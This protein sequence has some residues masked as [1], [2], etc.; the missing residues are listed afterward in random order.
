MLVFTNGR[1]SVKN[2]VGSYSFFVGFHGKGLK[3]EDL[4]GLSQ[5]GGQTQEEKYPAKRFWKYK[6]TIH[7][8][9]IIILGIEVG[10][11]KCRAHMIKDMSG[12]PA[13]HR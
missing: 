8:L 2:A 10:T 13:W 7:L 9:S 11:E 1:K 12:Y 3:G 6:L 4:A 5:K